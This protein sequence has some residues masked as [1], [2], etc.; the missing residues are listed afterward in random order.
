MGDG[1]RKRT[2][3]I[4]FSRWERI[5][6]ECD[7]WCGFVGRDSGKFGCGEERKKGKERERERERIGKRLGNE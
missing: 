1:G 2:L 6:E 3:S 4:R 7:E 5:R